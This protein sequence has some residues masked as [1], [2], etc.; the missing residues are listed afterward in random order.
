[1]QSSSLIKLLFLFSLSLL[2]GCADTSDADSKPGTASKDD[3]E[4]TGDTATSGVDSETTDPTKEDQ[5]LSESKYKLPEWPLK[6]KVE[7]GKAFPWDEGPTD[8]G[9][10]AFRDRLYKA[11]KEKDVDYLTSITFDTIH[12]SYGEMASKENFI[13]SYELDTKPETS[14]LWNE[15]ARTL[16]LGGAFY[17]SYGSPHRHFAAPFV[18]NLTSLDD[19]YTNGVIIGEK[20]RLREGPSLDAKIKGSLSWDIYEHVEQSEWVR[21]TINGDVAS[22]IHLKTENGEQGY[23]YGKFTRLPVD[24]RVGFTEYEKGKWRMDFFIAGD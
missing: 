15:L 19:P 20:V 5:K 16:E 17:D 21:D 3:T 23:V 4:A 14:S 6:P 13:K 10:K 8:P 22:W 2:I 24:F 7:K 9:F 11:I 18:N 1:M 12:F